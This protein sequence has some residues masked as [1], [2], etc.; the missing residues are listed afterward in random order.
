MGPLAANDDGRDALSV[1]LLAVLAAVLLAMRLAV[2][3]RLL[4]GLVAARAGL[5]GDGVWR[6]ALAGGLA[7]KSADKNIEAIGHRS[8]LPPPGE[9]GVK[10]ADVGFV[11]HCGKGKAISLRRPHVLQRGVSHAKQIW[12]LRNSG[13]KTATHFSWNCSE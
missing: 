13:R 11:P 7:F 8:V 5:G 1:V 2:T 10:F 4:V 6:D 3:D 12:F 9:S